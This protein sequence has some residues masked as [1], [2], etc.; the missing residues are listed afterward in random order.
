MSSV[1]SI[2]DWANSIAG[3]FFSGATETLAADKVLGAADAMIVK[4]D[5]GGSARDVTLP[6][7]SSIGPQGGMFWVINAADAAENL[8]VKND[9]GDTIATANQNESVLVYNAG[10]S[11]GVES[12]W[13]LVAVVSIA[14]S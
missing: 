9:A 11:G 1:F 12:S 13:V 4:L 3:N 8:V 5:P 2:P 10:Q 14:L 7:E 6:A